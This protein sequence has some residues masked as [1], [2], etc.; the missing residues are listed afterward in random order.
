M[1]ASQQNH[2]R[3]LPSEAKQAAARVSWRVGTRIQRNAGLCRIPLER[4]WRAVRCESAEMV[5]SLYADPADFARAFCSFSSRAQ[6]EEIGERLSCAY[7]RLK[8]TLEYTEAGATGA[9]TFRAG[10]LIA[11]SGPAKRPCLRGPLGLVDAD[12]ADWWKK[13]S[14]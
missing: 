5:E 4:V 1:H 11:A 12:P 3:T 14:D 6:A 10:R 9:L 13:D 7:L 8:I 2:R